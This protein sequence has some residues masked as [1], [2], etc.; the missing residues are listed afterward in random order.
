[1]YLILWPWQHIIE[2]IRNLEHGE[3]IYFRITSIFEFDVEVFNF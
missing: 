2:L 1:M 3:M